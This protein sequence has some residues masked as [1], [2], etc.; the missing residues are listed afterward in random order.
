MDTALKRNFPI[1]WSC[2]EVSALQRRLEGGNSQWERAAPLC[3]QVQGVLGGIAPCSGG[4]QQSWAE[5]R[6]QSPQ[7]ARG[8]PGTSCDS[9]TISRCVSCSPAAQL[10][11]SSHRTSWELT[12]SQWAELTLQA[13]SDALAHLEQDSLMLH[14]KCSQVLTNRWCSAHA[15]YPEP[16]VIFKPLQIP[17]AFSRASLHCKP[18]KMTNTSYK[19]LSI[20]SFTCKREK[21]GAICT[22]HFHR[23]HT[24]A[25]QK[26]LLTFNRNWNI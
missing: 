17:T 5:H 2:L 20:K 16:G 6:L 9:S 22:N 11:C 12:S 8:Q 24:E 18:L 1:P 15:P 7:D 21:I 23:S 13:F 26:P 25:L 10:P 4:T 19:S 14:T 3:R